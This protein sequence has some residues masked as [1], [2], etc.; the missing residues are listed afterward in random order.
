MHKNMEKKIV[1]VFAIFT[2]L[3]IFIVFGA[4]APDTFVVAKLPGFRFVLINN[5]EVCPMQNA[6][7]N[8]QA[9]K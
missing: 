3:K 6:L 8:T 4:P 9:M 1:L 5:S 7:N 2:M